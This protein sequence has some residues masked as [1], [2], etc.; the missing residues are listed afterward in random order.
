MILAPRS[1]YIFKAIIGY[2]MAYKSFCEY[3]MFA[4]EG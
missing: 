2:Q 4:L 1:K 3:F